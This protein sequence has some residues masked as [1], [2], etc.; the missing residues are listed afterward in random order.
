MK[1]RFI[2]HI[3]LVVLILVSIYASGQ[4]RKG[5][6]LTILSQVKLSLT[7][8]I[9]NSLKLNY[10]HEGDK[11]LT[12]NPLLGGEFGASY[13]QHLKN[14]IGINAGLSYGLSFSKLNFDQSETFIQLQGSKTSGS[15]HLFIVPISVQK[16]VSIGKNTFGSI[17]LGTRLNVV[18]Q[19]PVLYESF[20]EEYFGNIAVSNFYRAE[21]SAKR[22]MMSF[23]MKAGVIKLQDN[24]NSFQLNGVLNF[25]LNDLATGSFVFDNLSNSNS[26]SISQSI[27]YLG[28]E[29]VYSF[30]RKHY[31]KARYFS[32]LQHNCGP[33]CREKRLKRKQGN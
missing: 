17:E 24:K 3:I 6:D 25:S 4:N 21:L 7:P 16:L 12:S 1:I 32:P 31:E 22:S 29:F 23:M 2:Q 33:N 14:N 28:L 18:L 30:T 8:N 19:S 11:D 15:T 9:S 10:D 5:G 13:Y 27:N 26:G 20:Y